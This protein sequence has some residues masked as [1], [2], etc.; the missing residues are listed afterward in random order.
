MLLRKRLGRPSPE[1]VVFHQR[2]DDIVGSQGAGVE[3]LLS[4]FHLVQAGL[5][6]FAI[7]PPEGLPVFEQGFGR[8]PVIGKG[9]I[10]VPEMVLQ[11][12][13]FPP[14]PGEKLPV[15]PFRQMELPGQVT[16]L[17]HRPGAGSVHRG[18]PFG[19]KGNR[20]TF[21]CGSFVRFRLLLEGSENQAEYRL[22]SL[23]MQ[24][25]LKSDEQRVEFAKQAAELISTFGT[26]VEREIY[27]ARAAE[28]A[29]LTPEVMKLE[30]GKAFKRRMAR[31]Q[32]EQEKREKKIRKILTEEQYATWQT[33]RPQPQVLPPMPEGE[34]PGPGPRGFEEEEVPLLDTAAE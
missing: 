9:V 2:S 1:S 31:Q 3:L 29:G 20:L 8:L 17:V 34:R 10:P 19:Q 12:M 33:V 4:L 7:I 14:Q 27:G 25:D 28:A 30:I 5:V 24:F 15:L 23:Q 21:F 18:Q 26:A 32:K 11:E 13:D 22:R 6:P 16:G